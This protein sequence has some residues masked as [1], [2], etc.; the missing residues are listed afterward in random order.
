MNKLGL[1][2]T[3]GVGFR[4]YIMSDFLSEAQKQFE[5]IIIVLNKYGDKP[6]IFINNNWY[7]ADIPQ[8]IK[9]FN[10]HTIR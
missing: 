5:E 1:V 4:N 2:I 6:H 7:E 9:Y 8:H 10:L 3:D